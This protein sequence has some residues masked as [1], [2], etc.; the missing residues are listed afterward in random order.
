MKCVFCG[1]EVESVEEAVEL[2]WYPD[3]WVGDK[4]YQGPV[5]PECQKEHLDTDVD[6]EYVL[7]P[8][9]P[10]PPLALRS[11]LVGPRKE[12][13]M[14]SLT[15]KPKFPLGRLVATPGALEAL[16]ESGQSPAF[17]LEKHVSG[18]WGEVDAED[19]RA[20]DQALVDGSRLLSA[21]KTLKG[22][23]IWVITE[24]DRSSTC[25]LLPSEY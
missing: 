13:S 5:C 9:R 16:A 14:S 11:D 6:G 15:V 12:I 1:K 19:G 22:D 8:D 7:K 3:F 24:A 18:D 4:N 23:R 21:Y 17:F 25:C 10:V 2:G 20:N